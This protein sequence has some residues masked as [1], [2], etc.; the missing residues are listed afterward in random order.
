M[1]FAAADVQVD[2]MSRNANGI[3]ARCVFVHASCQFCWIWSRRLPSKSNCPPESVEFWSDRIKRSLGAAAVE[4]REFV[5][6]VANKNIAER[7][8]TPGIIPLYMQGTN[9]RMVAQAGAFLMPTT[10]KPFGENLVACLKLKSVDEILHPSK[11]IED[12][13]H[14][15]RNSL[16]S[17]VPL[18]KFVFSPE[19]EGEAWDILDQAN[20]TARTIYPDIVGIAKSIRYSDKILGFDM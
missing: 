13:S 1:S 2:I 18:V 16:P 7:S 19:L 5:F 3:F 20:V 6:S 4:L 9:A 17:D 15:R 8:S 11:R 10:F 12:I 14:E